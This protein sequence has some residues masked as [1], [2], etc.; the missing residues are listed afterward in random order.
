MDLGIALGKAQHRAMCFAVS[1]ALG[2]R[3]AQ[4]TVVSDRTS[5]TVP[6][7]H[8]YIDGSGTRQ[9][10]GLLVHG[11][12]A[13]KET[14]LLMASLLSRRRPLVLLDLPG[15]GRAS[16]ISGQLASPA[17]Q[18]RSLRQIMDAIGVH[19]VDLI[20]NSMGGGIGLRLAC[21]A[22][23]R[24]HS[25]TLINA[26]APESIAVQAVASEYNRQLE[27]GDNILVPE[28]PDQGVA[29]MEMLMS[30]RPLVPRSVLRYAAAQRIAARDQLQIIFRGWVECAPEDRLGDPGAIRC[31]TLVICGEKDRVVHP[32]IAHALAD[33]IPD[34]RLVSMPDIGHLPQLEAPRRT[35]RAIESFLRKARRA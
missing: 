27:R 5:L 16:P 25:L 9:I 4:V 23:D 14:W 19:R 13:D 12:G 15:F 29:M 34:A 8:R 6:Y 1:R 22:P 33:T 3:Q 24:I 26:I 30:R 32:G 10:P 2:L 17:A 28:D 20:G 31:P 7:L 11:F 18:A 21:D 35:A